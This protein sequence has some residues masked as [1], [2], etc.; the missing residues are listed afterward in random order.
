M[1]DLMVDLMLSAIFAAIVAIAYL[2]FK[3]GQSVKADAI[4][5]FLALFVFISLRLLVLD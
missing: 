2:C 3:T 5:I 4:R 1:L